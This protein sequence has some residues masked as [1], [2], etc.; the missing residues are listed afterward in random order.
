M[1]RPSRPPL[2]G[3]PSLPTRDAATRGFV[4]GTAR[5]R[6][7]E[8]VAKFLLL[9]GADTATRVLSRLTV[10]EM[11]GIVQEV[12]GIGSVEQR[13]AHRILEEFGYLMETRELYARGGATAAAAMLR[14]A[15]G[16]ERARVWRTR[17]ALPAT[18]AP[19]RGAAEDWA[20]G[21]LEAQE[22]PLRQALEERSDR[23]LACALAAAPASV[24]CRLRA[25]LTPGRRAALEAQ[26][27][28]AAEVPAAVRT[29]A[30][31]ALALQLGGRH[32]EERLPQ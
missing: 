24:A 22:A 7:F 2:D 32:P 25:C 10:A 27:Q 3:D 8:H 6:G 11:T 31:R 23:Q 4:R 14:A 13:E 30:L 1:N 9:L 20:L 5:D 17:L 18:P 16:E 29:G 28:C 12:A 26:A 19:R 15:F 21:L